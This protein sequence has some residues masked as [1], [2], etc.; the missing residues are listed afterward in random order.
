MWQVFKIS[1]SETFTD[2][3]WWFKSLWFQISIVVI[4]DTNHTWL[5]GC[6]SFMSIEHLSSHQDSYGLLTVQ[7][8]GYVIVV[9]WLLEIYVFKTSHVTSWRVPI[10]DSAHSWRMGCQVMMLAAW[11]PSGAALYSQNECTLWQVSTRPAKT[12]DIAKDRT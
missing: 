2:V 5:V 8:H 4:I 9:G 10:C 6:W 12:S 7:N 3:V 11:S 1:R